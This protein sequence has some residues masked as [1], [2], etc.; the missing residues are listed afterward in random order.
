L[1]IFVFG[2]KIVSNREGKKLKGL[3]NYFNETPIIGD[4]F[5]VEM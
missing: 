1:G 3:K 4:H 5:F 2:R